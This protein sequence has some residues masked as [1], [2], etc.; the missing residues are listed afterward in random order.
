MPHCV[1][2]ASTSQKLATV[3]LH[4]VVYNLQAGFRQQK[5]RILHRTVFSSHVQRL[6]IAY[7]AAHPLLM[8]GTRLSKRRGP[9]LALITSVSGMTKFYALI[10]QS[11]T[12]RAT[13]FFQTPFPRESTSLV[14]PIVLSL[15]RTDL[16]QDPSTDG[17]SFD[18]ADTYL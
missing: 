12:P 8:L 15:D 4:H 13:S 10:F 16:V 9:I 14:T 1:V 3:P 18:R 5:P 7:I 6:G 17:S 2:P 11:I